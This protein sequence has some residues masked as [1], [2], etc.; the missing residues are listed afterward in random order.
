VTEQ[1]DTMTSFNMWK[2][3]L[4]EKLLGIRTKEDDILADHA[5]SGIQRS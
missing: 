4:K 2:V 5:E 3:C 1:E